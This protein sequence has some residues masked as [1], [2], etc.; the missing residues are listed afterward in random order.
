MA[1]GRKPKTEGTAKSS[2][3]LKAITVANYVTIYLM[4]KAEKWTREKL[5]ENA[6]KYFKWDMT[7][8]DTKHFATNMWNRMFGGSEQAPGVLTKLGEQFKNIN[9]TKKRLNKLERLVQAKFNEL[10]VEYQEQLNKEAARMGRT[11]SSLF[12]NKQQAAEEA[13][14]QLT[15]DIEQIEKD[16]AN[17]GFNQK[18]ELL[19][20]PEGASG[21]A[22]RP[23]QLTSL[24]AFGDLFG[25]FKDDDMEDESDD[26]VE[27]D[28][29][30][31]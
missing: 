23:Y 20:L 5:A 3:I 22:S 8:V 28:T 11:G 19:W 4:A 15:A 1:K 25:A 18:G 30:V 27:D 12:V 10:P 29:E 2:A 31:E 6:A 13:L 17:V 7:G 21:G 14:I 9:T 24:D 16:A 26:E